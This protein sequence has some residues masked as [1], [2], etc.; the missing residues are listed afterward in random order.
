MIPQQVNA[1][2]KERGGNG[3]GW[4]RGH[5]NAQHLEVGKGEE[6]MEEA[7]REDRQPTEG[8]KC[9][10]MEMKTEKGR[11]GRGGEE[12]GRRKREEGGEVEARGR[13]VCQIR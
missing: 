13:T 6:A 5:G 11:E 7:D 1:D 4:V 12:G 3:R 8:R 9:R 2:Q 10:K